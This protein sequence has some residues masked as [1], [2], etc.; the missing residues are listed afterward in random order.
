RIDGDVAHIAIFFA[1]FVIRILGNLLLIIGVLIVLL[2][3]DW[4]ISLTLAIYTIIA[5][6]ALSKL[7]QIAVPTWKAA[8]EAN[9]DLFSFIE[10]QLSGTEDTRSSGAV[11]YVMKNLFRLN[12]ARMDKELKG[13]TKSIYIVASW[14]G[15]FGVGRI[16]SLLGSYYLYQSGVLT[17]G[18]VYLV[19]TYTEA[20][21]RPLREITNQIEQ[22]QQAAAGIERVESLY[23]LT[24]QIADTP[25]NSLPSGSLGVCF[26]QL[27]FA[28]H[29]GENI[30]HDIDFALQP[31]EV[32]GLLGRTG[33]GKTTIT[34]LLFRLYEAQQGAIQLINDDCTVPIQDVP[35]VELRQ[36]IGMV[37]QDVQ[38]FR[39]TVRDNLTFFDR[40]IM[41]KQILAVIH[42]L[43]LTDWFEG[44]SDGLDTELQTEGSS[45][46]AGEAQ[47]LAF[48]RVFLK[49][50]GLV[51]LD[52]ASSRLDPATEQLIERAVDKLL[53]N[54]TGIIVAHRL[55][56]VARA[57][58][59]MILG[60]GRIQ[61]YG[62]YDDLTQDDSS[63]FSQ[64]LQTGLESVM[65]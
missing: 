28:Y 4:R 32:L 40:R 9:A 44:L 37:T 23:K 43:G 53:A 10:E 49:D 59:I 11:A 47:L 57:D 63:Q 41:D 51:I 7:R 19:I 22:M 61:E 48:T 24:S 54:R 6:Y 55:G 14:N 30:L 58:K 20:I 1:Q 56:T 42:D 21:F 25:E 38:L 46:S 16:L 26:D 65:A 13:A 35:L 36:R 8:R 31:G 18:T 45:L 33:S 50:P 39:A 27:T 29:K 62:H 5:L 2:R 12:R 17:I 52:E 15:L 64:L 34:R 60:N 3:E